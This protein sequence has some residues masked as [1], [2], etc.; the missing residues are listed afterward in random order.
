MM[1]RPVQMVFG[2][3]PT[4]L[5]RLA[6]HDKSI[7]CRI[8]AAGEVEKTLKFSVGRNKS[9]VERSE[10]LPASFAMADIFLSR[11]AGGAVRFD[12]KIS[13]IPFYDF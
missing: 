8:P 9:K 4:R 12:A 5:P 3:E 6:E 1:S 13:N 10:R 2:H 11:Y 7:C